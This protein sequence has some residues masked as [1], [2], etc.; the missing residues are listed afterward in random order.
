MSTAFDGLAQWYAELTPE[1]LARIGELYAPNA[2]FQDPFN[3]VEGVER[4][5][6]IFRDMF[7]KVES[8]RFVIRDIVA[9]GP[10]GVLTWDFRFGLMGRTIDVHGASLVRLGE[11]GRVVYHRDYWD[12]AGELYEK[13]PV[14]GSLMRWLRRRMATH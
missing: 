3:R 5:A 7:E 8:P 11:D 10:T 6:A 9:T 4:I 1:S 14:V 12:A 13:L 2:S